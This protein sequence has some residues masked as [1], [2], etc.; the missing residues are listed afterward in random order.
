MNDELL[1]LYERR[2]NNGQLQEVVRVFFFFN[3]LLQTWLWI[4]SYYIRVPM[5]LL[6]TMRKKLNSLLHLQ[7]QYEW[8]NIVKK[9]KRTPF[10]PSE[11]IFV[12]R[13][14]STQENS[15]R[16]SKQHFYC[17]KSHITSTTYQKQKPL[18]LRS[19]CVICFKK[20]S[21]YYN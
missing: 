17:R 9:K 4:S 2:K 11:N 15:W 13:F 3:F 6:F 20:P 12:T 7:L 19:P 5:I 1:Q 16:C 8:L 14:Y 21:K 10:P 18:G